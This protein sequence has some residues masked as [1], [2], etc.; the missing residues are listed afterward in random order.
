LAAGCELGA[1]VLENPKDL[2]CKNIIADPGRDMVHSQQNDA[3]YD[4]S[5]QQTVF[6]S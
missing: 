6:F 1:L 5:Q 2:T 3:N 4:C